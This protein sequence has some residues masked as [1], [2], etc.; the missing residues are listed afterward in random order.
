MKINIPKVIKDLLLQEYDESFGDA[1]IHVWVNPPREVVKEYSELMS[2][3][4]ASRKVLETIKVDDSLGNDEKKGLLE[5]A[6][7]LIVEL[8][9]VGEQVIRWFSV[10]WSQGSNLEERWSIDEIRTLIRESGSTDP[11]L[12]EWMTGNTIRMIREHRDRSKKE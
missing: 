12:W 2:R 8:N 7:R 9:D 1:K 6:E 3:T 5:S 11:R 4:F 10:I